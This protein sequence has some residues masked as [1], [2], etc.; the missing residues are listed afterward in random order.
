MILILVI[1]MEALVR[2]CW[3]WYWCS[4]CCCCWRLWW[5]WWWQWWLW[6]WWRPREICHHWTHWTHSPGR[7]ATSK[8]HKGLSSK[9]LWQ[10]LEC[11]HQTNGCKR[12][13]KE[14]LNSTYSFCYAPAFVECRWWLHRRSRLQVPCYRCNACKCKEPGLVKTLRFG[15]CFFSNTPPPRAYLLR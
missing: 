8:Y 6:G 14:L 10:I 15:I 9:M 13:Q 2:W 4:C 1:I 12:M 11:F 5:W 7:L 3:W